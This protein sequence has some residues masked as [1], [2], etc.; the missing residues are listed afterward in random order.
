[1]RVTKQW[2]NEFIELDTVSND[3]LYKT[4]NA[5]G[6]EV[7]SIETLELPSKVVVG[8]ILSCEKHPNADK[9]NVCQVDVGN[10]TRQIVCGAANVVEAEYVAVATIGAILPNGLEIKHAKLRDVESAGMIC[11]SSEI[12]LPSMG[13]GIMQLDESIGTLEVGKELKEYSVLAD[14][15]IEIELT[16]NRGDCLSI[17]GVARDLSVALDVDMRPLEKKSEERKRQGVARELELQYGSTTDVALHYTL[18]NVEKMKSNF[19]LQLRLA[20]VNIEVQDR[21]SVL[22]NYAMH[23]TGVIVRAYNKSDFLEEEKHIVHINDEDGLVVVKANETIVSQVGVMQSEESKGTETTDSL[24]LEVSYMHPDK[25]VEAVSVT[26]ARTDPYY[27]Q[28]SRG[29][30]P[31][32]EF[33]LSYFTTLLEEN[34]LVEVY[35]GSLNTEVEFAKHTI[36]VDMNAISSIIGME[37]EGS[38][39]AKFLQKLGFGIHSAGGDVIAAVVPLFRHDIRNIQDIAEE[40]MRIIGIDNI[41]PKPLSFTEKVRLNSVSESFEVKKALRNRAVGVGFYENVSYLFAQRATLQA[42]GFATLPEA[43]ELVNP[44]V[45]ELNTLRTTLLTNMLLA[46]KRNVSYSQK[47]IALFEL[48]AVFNEK[49]EQDLKLAFLYAGDREPEAVSNSGKPESIDFVTFVGKVSSVIG[50]FDLQPCS[51][52]NALVH[53]YQSANIVINGSVVGFLTKL[54]PTVQEAYDLPVSFVAEVDYKA[55][56]PSHINAK[57]ISKFQSVTKDL[58]IVIDE[59]VQYH[60]VQAVLEDLVLEKVT[61]YY[62]IDIYTDEKLGS[63]KSLTLRF[64]I[65]SMEKTLEEG[66]IEEVMGGI[67]ERLSSKLQAELR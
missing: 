24:L 11:A 25:L 5:I 48:G 20:M 39:V 19:L 66:D 13:D 56:V 32:L 46:G 42:Y 47:T 59:S 6:L 22:L 31:D 38:R 58:S 49:R 12:G 28:T 17:Y 65:Q 3:T 45:E 64:H 7:D 14:T 27:Y 54:H 18:A 53:P 33:G 35:E 26:K 1:M 63:Q 43:L 21:L 9:L 23:T 55:L 34:A 4:L 60:K 51:Y 36:T 29:S 67:M 62:P 44:I 15:M 57:P 37:V 61:K 16:A 30:S 41:E 40:V 8:K 50:G 2:L 10:A 52:E